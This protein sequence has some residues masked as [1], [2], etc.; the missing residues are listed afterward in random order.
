MTQKLAMDVY[1]SLHPDTKELYLASERIRSEDGLASGALHLKIRPG[2]TFAGL[3]YQQL[4]AL[5]EG[6]HELDLST[7]AEVGRAAVRENT[8]VVYLS[9]YEVVVRCLAVSDGRRQ[10]RPGVDGVRSP[11]PLSREP[12]LRLK[13]TGETPHSSARRPGRCCPS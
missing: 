7:P 11:V 9:C 13:A 2:D 5:G 3:T 1:L 8:M 10:A 4:V 12:A 6:W